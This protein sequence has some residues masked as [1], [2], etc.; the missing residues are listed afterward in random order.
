MRWRKS[1]I[2]AMVRLNGGSRLHGD[3]H[4]QTHRDDIALTVFVES[5]HASLM[6]IKLLEVDVKIPLLCTPEKLKCAQLD[7]QHV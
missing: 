3:N 2:K 5:T 4:S 7:R 1:A 6:Y